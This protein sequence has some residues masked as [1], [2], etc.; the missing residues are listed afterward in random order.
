MITGKEFTEI[1]KQLERG[2][3]MDGVLQSQRVQA[4][5]GPAIRYTGRLKFN[6]A[7]GKPYFTHT[8]G[9]MVLHGDWL[10]TVT[11]TSAPEH[12][13]AMDAMA[14]K[15]IQTLTFY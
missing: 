10:Y 7:P 8:I 12:D 4:A 5:T 3:P 2:L 13:R 6:A 1:T 9:Y 14:E 15:S 11:Y